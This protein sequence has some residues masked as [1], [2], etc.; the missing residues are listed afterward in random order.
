M[1]LLCDQCEQVVPLTQL[2]QEDGALVFSCPGCGASGRLAAEPDV[3]ASAAPSSPE[4]P[5]SAPPPPEPSAEGPRLTVVPAP[6]RGPLPTEPPPTHCPKCVEPR[7]AAALSCARCG[8]VFANFRPEVVAAGPELLARWQSLRAEWDDPDAHER[9]LQ[10]AARLGALAPLGRLYRIQLAHDPDDEQAQAGRERLIAAV[11][12]ALVPS[13]GGEG[14][15][16]VPEA[17]PGAPISSKE[18]AR[19]RKLYGAWG[20]MLIFFLFFVV[21]R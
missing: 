10:E 18:L 15:G 8:L 7:A 5:A 13:S 3:P 2:R 12:S 19:R 9:L 11:T 6:A 1:K 16:P 21:C 20:V 17:G 14:E 4:P